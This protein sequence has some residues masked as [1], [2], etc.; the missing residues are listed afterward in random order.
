MEST[1]HFWKLQ[2]RAAI[3]CLWKRKLTG[4]AQKDLTN[5]PTIYTTEGDPIHINGK[6]SKFIYYLLTKSISQAITSQIRWNDIFPINNEDASTYWSDVYRRPYKTPKITYLL[7]QFICS[8]TSQN[9][10]PFF[11]SQSGTFSDF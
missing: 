7:G 3:P 10:G 2:I 6:S 9:N 4:P 11:L 5:K 1:F 8:M